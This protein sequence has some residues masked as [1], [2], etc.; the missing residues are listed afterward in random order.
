MS[1]IS[2]LLRF[3]N[4][5]SLDLFGGEWLFARYRALVS[6]RAKDPVMVASTSPGHALTPIPPKP[7][8]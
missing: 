5:N 7:L 6:H 4:A 8:S 3:A 2:R 1:H